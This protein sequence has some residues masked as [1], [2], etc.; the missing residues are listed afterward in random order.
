MFGRKNTKDL[1]MKKNYKKISKKLKK[2]TFCAFLFLT[3]LFMFCAC[4]SNNKSNNTSIN[5]S[6]INNFC[7]NGVEIKIH[8]KA[9]DIISKLGTPTKEESFNLGCGDSSLGYIYTYNGFYIVANPTDDIYYIEKIM[10][11][12]DLIS[13]P[14]GAYVGMNKDDIFK[15]YGD[16][17]AQSDEILR[18]SSSDFMLQ[19]DL[20]TQGKVKTI[21]Y[22]SIN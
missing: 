7:Y 19:F 14:E 11:T 1:L 9:Q 21:I 3:V 18:Y 10:I 17:D 22:K 16:P 8:S 2:Q 15:L 13:T 4:D 20:N 5:A 12:N 6:K